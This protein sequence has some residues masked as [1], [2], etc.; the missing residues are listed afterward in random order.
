MSKV[1][2]IPTCANPFEVSINGKKYLYPAGT[3]QEVP[4]EVAL[5]IEQH[6]KG[7]EADYQ[8]VEAPFDPGSGVVSYS[9]PQNLTEAQK[10]QAR[11]NIGAVTEATVEAV[12]AAKLSV[13]VNAEEVAY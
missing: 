6:H 3:V 9:E 7:H 5:I 2:T 13:I 10:A 12:V 1:V 4:D 11:E 8:P